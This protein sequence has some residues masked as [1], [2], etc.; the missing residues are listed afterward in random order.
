MRVVR[1]VSWVKN[2]NAE[3]S[4]GTRRRVVG[5]RRGGVYRVDKGVHTYIHA[6][7]KRE[8]TIKCAHYN[9]RTI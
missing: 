7:T 6:S 5:M 4:E 1:T 8:K 2:K 9:N 3:L